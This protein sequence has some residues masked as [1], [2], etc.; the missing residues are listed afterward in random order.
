MVPKFNIQIGPSQN[1]PKS[2][3]GPSRNWA[4]VEIGRS[5]NWPKSIALLNHVRRTLWNCCPRQLQIWPRRK[6]QIPSHLLQRVHPRETAECE[7]LPRDVRCDVLSRERECT[8][9][10]CALSTRTGADCVGDILFAA[11]GATT[12]API[13]ATKLLWPRSF[14]G[15]LREGWWLG[16]SEGVGGGGKHRRSVGGPSV[17]P[18]GEGVDEVERLQ[19]VF[20]RPGRSQSFMRRRMEHRPGARWMGAAHQ[21]PRPP[22]T[23]WPVRDRQS[24]KSPA[25]AAEVHKSP[26]S[27]RLIAVD[28]FQRKLSSPGLEQR[29]WRPQWQQLHQKAHASP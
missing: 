26:H 16:G 6:S 14:V 19:V 22:S 12:G 2:K 23:K 24:S 1:W 20:L 25:K 17:G 29:H 13:F 28:R 11:T 7:A 4:Q 8:P 9:F 21:G 10:Q 5:Q 3:V 27:Q 15:I 18:G